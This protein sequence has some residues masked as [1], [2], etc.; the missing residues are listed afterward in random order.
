MA[1][2]DEL[3]AFLDQ[4]MDKDAWSDYLPIGLLV[5]GRAEVRRLAAAVSA[6][7]EVFELADAWGADAVLVHHGMFWDNADRVLR[8]HVKK[9]VKFLL[10]RDITLIGYHLPLD[11]HPET[12]NN[13]LFAKGVGLRDIEPFGLYKG[14]R[15]GFRGRLDPTSV[16][17][18]V[19]RAKVFYGTEPRAYL[20]GPEKIETVG[21]IS[22]GA[23]EHLAEAARAGLD[24]F[25]TGSVDEP[26]Y[27]LAREEGIHFLSF[28]HYATERAG[29]QRLA[30]IV[31]EKF[32]IE[33]RFFDIENPG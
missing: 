31:A 4:T 11:A 23:W 6:G 24:C 7:L 14:K 18:F 9:R 15:I 29:V 1:G 8:G 22:G 10:E 16:G 27:S 25:V 30:E 5:E 26:A 32:N 3:I 21:V 33:T 28:G 17:D 12:G 2:R 13:I 20:Y 19:E